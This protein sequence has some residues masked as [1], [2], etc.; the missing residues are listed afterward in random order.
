MG[1]FGAWRRVSAAAALLGLSQPGVGADAITATASPSF[2]SGSRP[3]DVVRTFG[4]CTVVPAG[5][6]G[7]YSF[8]WSVV[9]SDA[10]CGFTAPTA[11][12]TSFEANPLPDGT[13][14]SVLECLVTDTV[15]FATFAVEVRIEY[16][17]IPLEVPL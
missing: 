6:S 17:I 5:G 16:S 9:S 7:S 10:G 15:T 14:I 8:A 3:F 4:P 1:Y 2:F 13:S 11:A 12:T